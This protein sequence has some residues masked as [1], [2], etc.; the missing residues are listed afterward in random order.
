MNKKQLPIEEKVNYLR[1]GLA[2][3]QITVNDAAA[4]VII[5]VYE[6]I[7]QKGGKFSVHDAAKIEVEVKAKYEEKTE[8]GKP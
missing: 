5:R 1:I 3:S 6:G 2:M 7:Q 8:G 4:E